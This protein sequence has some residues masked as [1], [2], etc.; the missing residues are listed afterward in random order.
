MTEKHSTPPLT[1]PHSLHAILADGGFDDTFFHTVIERVGIGV[2]VY[3]ETGTFTFANDTYGT[4]VG[5]DRSAIV[6]RR[7][8]EVNPNVD[9]DRFP[10]YWDSFDVGETREHEV[11]HVR[12]DGEAVPVATVT[13]AIEVDETVYHVGTISDITDR[14][15]DWAE[16][17]RQ[18]RRLEEVAT[19]ISHDLRNPLNVAMGRAEL[20]AM[21]HES[22]HLEYVERSLEKMEALIEAVLIIARKGSRLTDATRTPLEGAVTAAW[23]ALSDQDG[24]TLEMADDLG[25]VAS[26]DDRLVELFKPCFENAVEHA[27]PAVAVTV[28]RSED[29]FYVADDGPGIAAED[30]ETVMEYGY[31]TNEHGTGFGFSIVEHIAAAHGWSVEISEGDAGGLRIDIRDVDFVD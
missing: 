31:S 29:G 7:V 24:A 2:A 12:P 8:W 15:E 25:A 28:G 27:G 3:D 4:I 19:V 10:E 26:S 6:G 16:M 18:D 20:A 11:E 1:D 5:L 22:D 14:V 21:E 13:T 23:H 9:E 17:E 30:R